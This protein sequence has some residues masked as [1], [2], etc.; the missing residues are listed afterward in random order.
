MLGK[1]RMVVMQADAG[2]Y[3]SWTPSAR[4]YSAQG[5]GPHIDVL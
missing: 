3:R 4:N 5:Q 2:P 1:V